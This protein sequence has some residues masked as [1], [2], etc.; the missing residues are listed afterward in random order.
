MK[1]PLDCAVGIVRM[2]VGVAAPVARNALPPAFRGAGETYYA[3]ACG[4]LI[5]AA[6]NSQVRLDALAG[7]ITRDG[8]YHRSL[9]PG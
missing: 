3:D 8:D 4:P 6:Q 1:G 2:Q 5:D 7:D 9:C